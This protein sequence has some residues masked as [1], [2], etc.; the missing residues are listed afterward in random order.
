MGQKEKSRRFST[1]RGT[2]VA[3][4]TVKVTVLRFYPP[5]PPQKLAMGFG[6][7]HHH[8][9]LNKTEIKIKKIDSCT[10]QSSAL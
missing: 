9:P 2:T 10:L 4:A 3:S 5:P 1:V 6:F 7:S 8:H